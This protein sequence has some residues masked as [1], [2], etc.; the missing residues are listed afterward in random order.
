MCLA[1]LPLLTGGASWRTPSWSEPLC[2]LS[3]GEAEWCDLLFCSAL[4][5]AR[6][7]L[8]GRSRSRG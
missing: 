6:V 8:T 7:T 2:S 1:V 5:S 3:V 4:D